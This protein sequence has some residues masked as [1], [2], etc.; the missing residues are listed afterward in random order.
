MLH[1]LTQDIYKEFD[2]L[3]ERSDPVYERLRPV[4]EQEGINTREWYSGGKVSVRV[5]GGRTLA[6]KLG[7]GCQ[8]IKVT[9][10][11]SAENHLELCT[12]VSQLGHPIPADIVH[13]LPEEER[14]QF[15]NL[16]KPSDIPSGELVDFVTGA[17]ERGLADLAKTSLE[18]LQSLSRVQIAQD[19]VPEPSGTTLQSIIEAYIESRPERSRRQDRGQ[20]AKWM[21]HPEMGKKP[22]G[23]VDIYDVYDF[24]NE[25]G[26]DLS[27]SSLR[28]FRAAMSNVYNWC[29]KQRDLG[30]K[31]NPW[32]GIDMTG[33]GQDAVDRLPFTSEQLHHLFKLDMPDDCRKAF[34]ILVTTGLRGG[35]L[36]QLAKRQKVEV[37]DGIKFLDLR[38]IT[39][40]NKGSK[41]L[42]PLHDLANELPKSFTQQKLRSLVRRVTNDPRVVVHSLRHTAKDL[43]RDAGISKEVSDFITGHAQGDVSGKYGVGPS[44]QV[45]YEAINRVA[46]PWLR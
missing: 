32:R 16:T 10:V 33:M 6:A 44:L 25:L 24:L 23:E 46:H 42:V 26:E 14:E 36:V 31:Y 18:K 1:E 9:E 28:V 40:K 30:I 15:L 39:T 35:E 37:K 7:M 11:W 22:L 45:R 2:R 34:A 13:L 20:L 27:V 38:E 8:D 19:D 21:Q 29:N 4:L 5:T 3:L 41:R 17:H 43:F 12:L